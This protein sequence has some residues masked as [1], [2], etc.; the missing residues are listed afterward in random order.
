MP[1]NIFDLTDTSDLPEGFG[2][3]RRRAGHPDK[4]KPLLEAAGRPVTA[5]EVQAA[6]F[7]QT[8][9]R[10]AIGSV[11]RALAAGV[12]DGRFRRVGIG[13][14]A[15]PEHANITPIKKQA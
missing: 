3:P 10:I 13:L 1:K 14:Y 5:Y 8:K 2:A 11:S 7:R 6:I 4:Y 15:L 9:Q 12:V